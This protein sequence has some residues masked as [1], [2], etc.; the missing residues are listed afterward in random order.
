[1]VIV[2]EVESDKELTQFIKLP[3]KVYKGD[4]KW[5]PPLIFDMKHMFNKEKF[6]YF[7]FGEAAFF[8]AFRD[9]QIVGRICAH[10]NERHNDYHKSKDG[11]FGFYECL[12]DDEAS[13]ALMKT[14]ENWLK[15]K[16]MTRVIGP[17]NYT[18][19]DEIGFLAEG[20][21]N[22]PL[23]PV[24]FEI[25]NP[26][27]YVEQMAKAGYEKEIDWFSYIV[28][29]DV[30]V[31]D[32]FIKLKE[33][34]IRHGYTFR[35]LDMKSMDT[36]VEYV[37]EIVRD[38]WDENWGH[39][40]PSDKQFEHV[41]NAFK[42]IV[43]PRFFFMVEKDGDV[44]ACS[45]TLPD[46]NPSVKKMNGRLFPF[47][48]WHFTRAKKK[49]VGMR[50]FLFGVKKQYRNKGL[51][52]VMITDTIL[53]GRKAGFDWSVCSLIV[54]NNKNII[55]PILKWGGKLYRTYRLFQKKI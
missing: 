12:D 36:E 37:K 42:L 49:A 47:G 21:E 33:R 17:E 5:V 25:Y 26:R 18:I 7:E 55:D 53:N 22:P 32:S 40:Q 30:V 44:V 13:L 23:S 9:R 45:I 15:A 4:D 31:K 10:I 28:R 54:E 29:K 2:K 48:W 52:V 38:A 50:T 24:I 43:D 14:A 6:H 8:L 46:I 3:W 20:R 35:S 16:G 34:L 19:Y 11:F 41:K 27:Y 51:D 1:M 39:V